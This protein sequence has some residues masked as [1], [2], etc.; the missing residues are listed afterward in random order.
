M[1]VGIGKLKLLRVE[2]RHVGC[3][4][5]TAA[6]LIRFDSLVRGAECDDLVFHSVGAK[7]VREIE[8]G[9]GARLSAHR[10]TVEFERRVDLERFPHHEALAVVIG[11]AD[12]VAVRNITRQSPRRVAR[13]HVDLAGLEW[14]ESVFSRERHELDLDRVIQDRRRK[15]AT[16]VDIE[17]GPIA[18]VVGIG[19]SRQS[20]ADAASQH[21]AILY[22]LERLGRG[23]AGAKAQPNDR[24]K[25][26][27]Y[28]LHEAALPV[29]VPLDLD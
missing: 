11:H 17:A 8:F 15:G 14:F 2:L 28:A 3:E 9:R 10:R 19:K 27:D 6:C 22:R 1:V 12:E 7:E 25:K 24:T 18:L 4:Y 16:E 20:L 5:V 21:A 13:Q 26:K 23:G 29:T